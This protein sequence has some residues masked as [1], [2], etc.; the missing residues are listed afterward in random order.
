MVTFRCC[1]FARSSSALVGSVA[2]TE[3]L[4]DRMRAGDRVP[5]DC[6]SFLI[7]AIVLLSTLVLNTWGLLIIR[8]KRRSRCM[9]W[10][11]IG[12]SGQLTLLDSSFSTSSFFSLMIRSCSVCF[13]WS[14]SRC[15][16]MCFLT[17]RSTSS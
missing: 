5:S 1:C 15:S 11:D 17:F 2:G 4:F 10:V 6:C 9:A 13:S 16:F 7:R 14:L 12:P 8:R 3:A